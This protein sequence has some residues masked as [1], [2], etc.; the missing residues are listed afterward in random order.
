LKARLS[1]VALN[2][3]SIFCFLL[4]IKIFLFSKSLSASLSLAESYTSHACQLALSETNQLSTLPQTLGTQAN[5]F[6][7]KGIE[8]MVDGL[9]DALVL[10]ISIIQ[11]LVIFF[12]NF[13]TS[14]YTCLI[15]STVEG[16]V[17][18]ALNATETIIE[19]TNKTI[20]VLT[21]SLQN[22]FD[23]INDLLNS[24]TGTINDISSFFTGRETSLKQVKLTLGELEDFHIPSDIN[25]KL[26][27]LRNKIPNFE[28]VQNKTDQML[29]I[30]FHSVKNKILQKL[31]NNGIGYQFDSSQ[32]SAPTAASFSVE[33]TGDFCSIDQ[34]RTK[35]IPQIFDNMK[36][37][38]NLILNI[39]L[40]VLVLF[41]ILFIGLM[42]F[43]EF[44]KWKWMKTKS[45][46]DSTY[47]EQEA[48]TL[49]DNIQRPYSYRVG[50][51]LMRNKTSLCRI[52][53]QWF[54][55]FISFPYSLNLLLLSTFGLMAVL[56]QYILL[57]KISSISPNFETPASELVQHLSL[58]M[59][60]QASSWIENTN[61]VMNNTEKAINRDL[62][63]WVQEATVAANNTVSTFMEEIT[64]SLKSGFE[65]TPLYKP[66]ESVVYCLI[67]MKL[68][69]IEKGLTWVHQ[70]A[71][72]K[73]PRVDE[74]TL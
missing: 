71:T 46:E 43:K 74:Q 7:A 28:S 70:K 25:D 24:A 51:F 56:L 27:S 20:S 68:E 44:R 53:T 61:I 21:D 62:L 19:Y 2:K 23:D 18:A 73:F 65:G 15:M 9:V 50:S 55:N 29:S 34:N 13:M 33:N 31:G 47:S 26:E 72:I 4:I 57:S 40:I 48:L 12:V 64:T 10:L 66:I 37:G 69:N 11:N 67:G 63:G 42:T 17:S 54:I 1:Q 52:H 14:T 39:L 38:M 49:I 60:E 45:I 59:K 5:K 32:L 30:P 6:I 41:A 22:G 16:T 3:Y 36:E 58:T 35:M 8:T